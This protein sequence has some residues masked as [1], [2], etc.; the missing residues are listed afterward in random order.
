MS[1]IKKVLISVSALWFITAITLTLWA[2]FSVQ[3]PFTGENLLPFL[4]PV[5][6]PSISL[7][8]SLIL[9]WKNKLVTAI[10]CLL[11]GSLLVWGAVYT[12]IDVAD[13]IRSVNSGYSKFTDNFPQYKDVF[14]SETTDIENYLDIEDFDSYDK[15]AISLFFPEVIPENA[16]YPDYEFMYSSFF[17]TNKHLCASWALPED[18]FR[19]EMKR[20]SA[21]EFEEEAPQI[22]EEGSKVTFDFG[23]GL[24]SV[25]FDKSDS[26]V[27]YGYELNE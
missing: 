25:T 11:F 14:V 7:V 26:R 24:V 9:K 23:Q 17:F 12:S 13:S 5:V 15:E 1:K 6:C 19:A 21:L 18:D 20:I 22:Y 4:L 10:F 27:Y 2:F 3:Y 8:L 16:V